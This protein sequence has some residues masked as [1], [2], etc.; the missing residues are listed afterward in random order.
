MYQRVIFRISSLKGE[1]CRLPKVSFHQPTQL[2]SASSCGRTVGHRLVLVSHGSAQWLV[3]KWPIFYSPILSGWFSV[4]EITQI[5]PRCTGSADII[6]PLRQRFSRLSV[7]CRLT[8]WNP[9]YA[10]RCNH[11]HTRFR[12]LWF[13]VISETI[14][15]SRPWSFSKVFDYFRSQ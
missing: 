3:G 1:S 10:T 7:E 5:Y 9:A 2:L 13:G 15:C 8:C 4:A 14:K 11:T 12:L 6:I